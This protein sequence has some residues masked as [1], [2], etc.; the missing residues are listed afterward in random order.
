MFI[1]IKVKEHLNELIYQY[2]N[3]S[4]I[5]IQEQSNTKTNETRYTMLAPDGCTYWISKTQFDKIEKEIGII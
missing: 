3:V 1:K 4:D 5:T 2:F